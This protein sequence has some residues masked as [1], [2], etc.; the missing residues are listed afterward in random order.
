MW[1][2]R[3]NSLRRR[4]DRVEG[5]LALAAG[6]VIALSVP[7][8]GVLASGAVADNLREHPGLHRTSAELLEDAPTMDGIATETNSPDV[9]AKA[10]WK[11]E[12]GARR[13]GYTPVRAGTR[14]HTRVTVWLD[15][16]GKPQKA[17]PG[18]NEVAAQSVA[19][20]GAAATG[21]LCAAVWGFWTVRRRLDAARERDW[22]REWAVVGPQWSKRT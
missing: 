20:G 18:I 12:D 3:H 21:T 14:A 22:E 11:Q 4:S 9:P 15:G 7:T 2:W 19:A 5:W 13:T 16:R 8:T 17:P 1:R 10:R 6:A